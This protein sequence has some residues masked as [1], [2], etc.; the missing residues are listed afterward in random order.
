[1]KTKILSTFAFILIT[2]LFVNQS[3]AIFNSY[4]SPKD[5]LTILCS[6]DL[7]NL[8]SNLIKEYSKVNPETALKTLPVK[9]P[10]ITNRSNIIFT[11]S[12]YYSVLQKNSEWRMII[13]SDAIVPII[14]QENP[15]IGDLELN[16]ITSER[17]SKILTSSESNIWETSKES[18]QRMS[19]KCYSLNNDQIINDLATYA[20]VDKNLLKINKV[21]SVEELI[22]TIKKDQTS[23][24]F[25]KVSDIIDSKTQNIINGIRILPLDKNANGKLD[26]TEKIY[27]NL[28]S[29]MHGIWIGKYPKELCKNIYSIASS[30]PK[31]D[32]EISFLGWVTSDG[33]KYL[34]SSGFCELASSQSQANI[35]L[36]Y[37][38]QV[39]PEEP[40]RSY[41]IPIAA[42]LI[43]I[44]IALFFIF[45]SIIPRLRERKATSTLQPESLP[46][47]DANSVTVPEGL[48]FDKS[49]TWAFMEK[50]GLVGIGIDD[51]LQHVTGPITKIKM[52]E[53]GA[54]VKKGEPFLTIVQEGKQLSLKAPISGTIKA[55]NKNLESNSV[56]VNQS[57]YNEGWI[58]RIEPTNWIRE[59]QFLIFAQG[60]KEWI[61]MEFLHLKDFLALVL[62][63]KLLNTPQVVLQDGG[64]I[65][66]GILKD[67]KPE[68]WEDFQTHFLDTAK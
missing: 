9:D 17:I 1:M 62:K 31:N 30:E 64:E 25:C 63:E 33:Q 22:A 50:D 45:D 2:I 27:D 44:V 67:L 23:I 46:Y 41:I 66:N 37:P 34:N 54:S 58:Y 68:I 36:L 40:N 56:L 52:K 6:P 21:E 26:N 16:G 38:K 4:S 35:D 7:Y 42:A 11:S 65:K 51:F 12:D 8:T 15:V 60:Y 19:G 59:T 5:T 57:P 10:K 13:G 55:I 18:K 39:K 28:S 3:K 14:S 53:I 61:K 20:K 49:H 24:G 48:F 32:T 29:F 47:F 43:I